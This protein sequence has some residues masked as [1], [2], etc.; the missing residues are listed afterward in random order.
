MDVFF[1]K[2]IVFG[3]SLNF[4]Y[5]VLVPKWCISIFVCYHIKPRRDGRAVECTG[6]ENQQ[7]L[8]PF[9]GSNPCLSGFQLSVLLKTLWNG[10]MS[11]IFHHNN[12]LKQSTF[13][14]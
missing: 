3:S 4:S 11:L 10:I 2:L 1:T 7:G 12:H 5:E 6:L 14:V 8:T 9:Q 13:F